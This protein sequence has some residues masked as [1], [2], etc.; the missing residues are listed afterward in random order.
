[1]DLVEAHILV[2]D[3]LL[4][5]DSINMKFNLGTGKG[6]SVLELI[7]YFEKANNIEVPYIFGDR[8]KG[9]KKILVADNSSF[10][11]FFNWEPR[12]TITQ[13]CSDGWKWKL[14]NY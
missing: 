4:S 10:K 5:N 11:S 6:T 13:M 2:L 7:D 14:S 12:R 9:D 3:Y 8:R 1:M